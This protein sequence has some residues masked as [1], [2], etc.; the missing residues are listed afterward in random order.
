[1]SQKSQVRDVKSDDEEDDLPIAATLAQAT[2]PKRA[3][4]GIRNT[5][6]SIRVVS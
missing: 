1:M 3:A 6:C 4:K 2:K 5:P